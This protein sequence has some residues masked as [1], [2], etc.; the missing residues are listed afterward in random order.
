MSP[1]PT[2]VRRLAAAAAA[3]TAAMG[4]RMQKWFPGTAQPLVISAPMLGVANAGLA[5]AVSRAGG[6]GNL[7]TFPPP[8]Q[9]TD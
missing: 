6:L 2:A 9:S 7:V 3:T 4:S 1:T 5:A 8:A